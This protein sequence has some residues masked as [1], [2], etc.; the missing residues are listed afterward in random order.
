LKAVR[1][2]ARAQS[3]VAQESEPVLL[4]SLHETECLAEDHPR[5]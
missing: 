2:G 4:G 3:T 1:A 5:L